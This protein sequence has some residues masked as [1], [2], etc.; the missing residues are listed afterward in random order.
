MNYTSGE[1]IFS[2]SDDGLNINSWQDKNNIP[3]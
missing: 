1:H 2:A 3:H